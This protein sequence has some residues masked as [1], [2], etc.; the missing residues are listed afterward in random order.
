[1]AEHVR[2]F[3]L[4]NLRL[5]ILDEDNNLLVKEGN[6]RAEW[7][8]IEE[9]ADIFQLSNYRMVF[10]NANGTFKY[11]EGNLYQPTNDLPVNLQSAVM[12]DEQPVFLR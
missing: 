12:N 4:T 11:Q 8:R 7:I 10:H 6:L 5:G 3:Q 1:M 2:A 9:K